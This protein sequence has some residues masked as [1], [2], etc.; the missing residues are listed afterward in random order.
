[1]RY[2]LILFLFSYILPEYPFF[3][4]LNK[5][6]LFEKKKIS[7]IDEKGEELNFFG[8]GSDL[9]LANPLGYILGENPSYVAMNNPVQSYTKKWRT[10]KIVIDGDELSEKAFIDY[11]GLES[12]SKEAVENENNYKYNLDNYYAKFHSNITINKKTKLTKKFYW[13]WHGVGF[14]LAFFT[15][16][17]TLDYDP[18]Y[19]D[20]FDDETPNY[21]KESA[22]ATLIW[23]SIGQI[24]INE[25]ISKKEYPNLKI[26]QLERVLTNEQISQ[27][28]ES[29]NRNLYNSINN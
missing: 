27:L 17:E 19:E 10:F 20:L 21:R 25:S 9:V 29:Y 16:G 18:E 26:P 1:M 7:I 12:L 5:Q 8:G 3:D 15:F 4:D 24:S 11:V 28:S 14:V 22:L 6:L 2:L 13:L 23:Y